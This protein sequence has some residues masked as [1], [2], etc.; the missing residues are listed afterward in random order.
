MMLQNKLKAIYDRF[1][2]L[3]CTVRHYRRA[4]QPPFVVWAEEGEENSFNSGNR[5]S[6]QVITGSVDL[7]TLAEF[8]PLVDEVQTALADTSAGWYLESV[9][10]EEETNLIHYRWSWRVSFYGKTENEGA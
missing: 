7:Y 2:S 6:E 9:Q 10:Y 1:Q 4:Q 5:K 8:D 3:P